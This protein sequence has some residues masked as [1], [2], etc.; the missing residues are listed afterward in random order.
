[1]FIVSAARWQFG[2]PAGGKYTGQRQTPI[3]VVIH[4]NP[5]RCASRFMQKYLMV[6]IKFTSC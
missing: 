5:M 6:A 4:T 3:S 1:M 2:K